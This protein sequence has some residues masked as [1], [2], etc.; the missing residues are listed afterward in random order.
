M[1]DKLNN[2]I[3][4]LIKRLEDTIKRIQKDEKKLPGP[5]KTEFSFAYAS[6]R[7]D[8]Y[9]DVINNLKESQKKHNI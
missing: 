5:M 9:Q 4:D 1:G 7:K 6:G 2:F 3:L 8:A